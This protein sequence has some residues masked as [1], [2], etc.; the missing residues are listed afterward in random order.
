MRINGW[1]IFTIQFTEISEI[2]HCVSKL[3]GSDDGIVKR[4]GGS[5]KA[6]YN[7]IDNR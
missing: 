6:P 4:V 5:G 7:N 1:S 2:P 3:E